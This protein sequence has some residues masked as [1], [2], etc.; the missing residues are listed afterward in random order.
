MN[1]KYFSEIYTDETQFLREKMQYFFDKSFKNNDEA[2]LRN[3]YV[4][5]RKLQFNEDFS[6][7]TESIEL[8]SLAES[9]TV[10]CD[11][12][13]SPSGISFIFCGDEPCYINGNQKMISKALLNLLSNAYLYGNR[14][15]VTVK[16]VSKNDN[17]RLEVLSGG[18]FT[19]TNKLGKGLSFVHK[20]CKNM[21][22][23]FLIEQSISHTKA[24]M[25]FKNA[26]HNNTPSQ[27]HNTDIISLL[28]DRL[29]P[30]CVEM[31]GM[32]YH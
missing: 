23:S 20:A 8:T 16:T 17:S 13:A 6:T 5:L 1:Y 25:I 24:I 14:N 18:N 28:S 30:A 31:F 12:L 26:E 10:A 27:T 3:S 11:I 21:Q 22:G 9:V 4:S 29:S 19:N 32:E 15:L 7:E 2:L